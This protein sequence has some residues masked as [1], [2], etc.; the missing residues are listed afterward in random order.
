MRIGILSDSHGKSQR[1]GRGI[2]L[3]IAARAEAIVHCGDIENPA[4]VKLLGDSGVAS[5]LSAGNMDVSRF[6][7]LQTAAESCGVI[8]AADFVAVPLDGANGDGNCEYKKYLAATHGKD[9]LLLDELIRDEAYRY[10]CHGHTHRTS[11]ERIG[12]TRILNPGALY[13]PRG[14]GRTVMLLDTDRD[15]VKIISVM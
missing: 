11:D 7:R 2:D 6:G 12:S 1:L 8:F 13:N 14:G 9:A 3:L 5:Y 4:G 15:I 10:V